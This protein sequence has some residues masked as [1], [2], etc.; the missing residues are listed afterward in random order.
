MELYGHTQLDN[1]IRDVDID[2]LVEAFAYD[3]ISRM[4][5]QQIHEFLESD[6]GIALQERSVLKKPTVIRLSK[7]D[8][9]KRR[10]K[11]VCYQLARDSKDPNF[12][13]MMKYR[14]LMKKYRALVFKKHIHKAA[15]IAKI[16]QREYIKRARTQPMTNNDKLANRA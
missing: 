4:T 1:D 7:A 14:K 15:R 5:S 2:E 10:I 6:A 13:K 8:D 16:S 9:E 11:L 12:E 3:D